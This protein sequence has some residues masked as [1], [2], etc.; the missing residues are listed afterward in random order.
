MYFA[1]DLGM[2]Q[3]AQMSAMLRILFTGFLW[4]CIKAVPLSA[5]ARI[6]MESISLEHGLSDRFARTIF[7]DKQGFLWIGT[8]NGLNRYDGCN[9]Y[10][11]N[12]QLAPPYH[13]SADDVHWIAQTQRGKIVVGFGSPVVA[14]D[15][16]DPSTG[17]ASPMR[18]PPQSQW[19]QLLAS[20][21]GHL[22]FTASQQ[23]RYSLYRYDEASAK[24]VHL[25]HLPPHY[26]RDDAKLADS[27]GR[28]WMLWREAG[29]KLALDRYDHN[30]KK[31]SSLPSSIAGSVTVDEKDHISLFET[32]S[33][34][35]CLLAGRQGLFFYNPQSDRFELRCA[36]PGQFDFVDAQEDKQGNI[37]IKTLGQTGQTTG[38]LLVKKNS[39]LIDYSWLKEAVPQSYT[40]YSEDYTTW[41]MACTGDG[42]KRLYYKPPAVRTF[43][44]NINAGTA[45]G[46]SIRGIC[47]DPAGRII[48]S[49][50][51]DGWHEIDPLTGATR[52][53]RQGSQ[54]SLGR[55]MVSAPDGSIWGVDNELIQYFPQTATFKTWPLPAK[56]EAFHLSQSGLLWLGF[57]GQ[58]GTLTPQDGR[59]EYWTDASGLNPLEGRL[60]NFILE[61]QDGSIWVGSDQGLSQIKP[62][63][64]A[65]KFYGAQ[66]GLPSTQ[67]TCIHESADHT[68]W[69]GTLGGGLCKFEPLSERVQLVISRTQGL[70]N[71]HI[72]GILPGGADELWVSTYAGLSLVYLKEKTCRNFFQLDGFL[73]DEF[74][75]FSFFKDQRS[76]RMYWGSIKGLSSFLPAELLEKE[77]SAPI[78]LSEMTYFDQSG[79]KRITTTH[80]KQALLNDGHGAVPPVFIHPNNRFLKLRFALATFV[81]TAQNQYA[82]RI[83]G[84]HSDWNALGP[85]GELIIN[86][87]PTGRYTLRIKAADRHGH[88]GRQ[89]L[90]LPI[91]VLRYWYHQWWAWLLWSSLATAV[92]LGLYYFREKRLKLQHQYQLEQQEAA[93]LKDLN[94]FKN[95]LYAN[96]THEFRPPLT[97]MLGIARQLTSSLPRQEPA[98]AANQ[99]A[100]QT[101]LKLM[102]RNGQHLLGLVNQMLDLAKAEN[103]TLKMNKVQ[104]DILPFIHFVAESFSSLAN[105]QN[106]ILKVESR[107]AQLLM[108]YEPELLRQILSNL[109]TNGLKYTP[110]GGR[111][112]L[113]ISRQPTDAASDTP[114]APPGQ[115]E[116]WLKVSDTGPGIAPEDLPHVFNRF[117][118]G[119]TE[120]EARALPSGSSP[121]WGEQAGTGIGLALVK[122]LVTLLSGH[123]KVT[124]PVGEGAIFLVVLPITHDAPLQNEPI[125]TEVQLASSLQPTPSQHKPS[126]LVVED[127]ADIVQYLQLCLQ[128]QYQLIFAYNGH[129]GLEK[130][131]SEVPDI[132]LSD[133]IMPGM[134]GF[135]LCHALKTDSR[136]SHIPVVML[137]AKGD[138][139]SRIAG[140]RQGADAY[141]VKPFHQEEL[142]VILHNLLQW[143]Q[144]LQAHYQTAGLSG[145]QPPSSLHKAP[146][147][148]FLQQLRELIEA[149]LDNSAL[150]P[151]DI[152]RKMGMGHTNLNLKVNAL[153]GMPISL[154]IRQM[155]LHK[156]KTL[157]S[158]TQ[159]TVSEIA[160]QTGFN[161]P[162]YFSR[163]FAEKYGAP[164]SSFR[165]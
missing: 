106:V 5:Q 10:S 134:D 97:V 105:Q 4:L 145:E 17:Q 152:C 62:Q 58:I 90:V 76:G 121:V 59:F 139:E 124:S 63:A 127:N 146:E 43:L 148:A 87:L 159:L 8:R 149:E 85:N 15:L 31:I 130:A 77:P 47:S 117:F 65:F 113:E 1:A 129:F 83:D 118:S 161:D 104:A 66:H 163:V 131:L 52:H 22:F 3:T 114:E 19:G 132:I 68:L 111:L 56:V 2:R 7:R 11:Y 20:K 80:F 101:Q 23:Q 75:R 57:R 73:H 70:A 84:L 157:L 82:Y 102:E 100:W 153:T 115:E 13:I 92:L 61:T 74:N 6:T 164:P 141:L 24:L 96:I 136:T 38:L 18:P 72:A 44:S 16:L 120:L 125:V 98:P 67:V 133:V 144:K 112:S 88:W 135:E 32:S 46:A 26:Q 49:T 155:R 147:D 126:I 71:D 48:V 14:F 143:R 50:E 158:T 162:K 30:G 39:Q 91:V 79:E 45:Y 109:L 25:I 151:Q 37:F 64:R 138:V 93:R 150:S 108:D 99:P 110:S 160:Y 21:N 33:G 53:L 51:R 119:Q 69:L 128:D 137:T 35:I 142:L 12:S 107:E 103:S 55:N 34:E 122:E 36:I 28:I 29:G 41:L 86:Y 9:M 60:T 123:I 95:R 78:L 42:L 40:F 27:Q 116:L 165:G 54:L 156:A 154:F 140:L 94:A 89:E 81:H